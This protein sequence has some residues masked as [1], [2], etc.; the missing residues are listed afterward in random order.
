MTIVYQIAFLSARQIFIYSNCALMRAIVSWPPLRSG[1]HNDNA[2]KCYVTQASP[3]VNSVVTDGQFR[4][5][6][7]YVFFIIVASA[8]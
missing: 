1:P 6:G 7:R 5:D 2:G 8:M 3:M 4:G